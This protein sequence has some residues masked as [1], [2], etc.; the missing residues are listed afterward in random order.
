M[1]KCG[2][3]CAVAEVANYNS[4]CNGGGAVGVGTARENVKVCS[5]SD[6]RS[7]KKFAAVKWASSMYL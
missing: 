5:Y 6:L 1:G 4:K 2:A 7:S 3:N